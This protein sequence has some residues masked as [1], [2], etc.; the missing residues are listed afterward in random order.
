MEGNRSRYCPNY[1]S[2]KDVDVDGEEEGDPIAIKQTLGALRRESCFGKVQNRRRKSN[3]FK[4]GKQTYDSHWHKLG[5]NAI[6]DYE[7]QE[8]KVVQNEMGE[9]SL[10]S[11]SQNSMG[12]LST[13]HEE[14]QRCSIN[15]SELGNLRLQESSDSTAAKERVY[16]IEQVLSTIFSIQ[17]ASTQQSTTKM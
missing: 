15:E 6:K 4:L 11:K 14:N 12:I 5:L 1:K 16:P 7:E 17:G 2:Y 8:Q 9:L 13:L 3:L 10:Q